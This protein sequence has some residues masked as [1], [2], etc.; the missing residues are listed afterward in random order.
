[1]STTTQPPPGVI[2]DGNLISKSLQK[3][4]SP[5]HFLCVPYCTWH[6]SQSYKSSAIIPSQAI[7]Q[8][9]ECWLAQYSKQ[10]V[11]EDASL[12]DIDSSFMVIAIKTFL[13]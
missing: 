2:P 3:I 12:L 7:P 8:E 6:K 1:M 9:K 4:D 10:A 5:F 13:I 11:R